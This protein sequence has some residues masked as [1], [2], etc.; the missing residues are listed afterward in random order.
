MTEAQYQQYLKEKGDVERRAAEIREKIFQLAGIS[1]VEMPSFGQALEIAQWVQSQTGV[2]P[3]FLL[4]IITQESA[5]ARNV[6]QCYI[7]NETTG[8]S[9]HITSGQLYNKGIHSTRDLPLFLLITKELGKNPLK[10]PISCY[11]PMCY[12]STLRR[13]TYTSMNINGNPNCPVGYVP[14]GFGGAMGP[15]QFIPSTWNSYKN[16][17]ERRL[18]KKPSPWSVRDSFLA[19]GL[20]LES[21]GA[22]TNELTAAAKYFGAA[23]IGYESSV[24]QRARC[25]Q[26]FIDNGT[27]DFLCEGLIFIPQ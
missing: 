6:G 26:T 11:I 5:L 21:N 2:R 22:A 23:N 9:I 17:L 20:L 25:I 4:S 16:E 1:E 3:A 13:T 7:A 19:A 8:A 12:S 27:I 10:T 24:M 18:G 15:A 14:F